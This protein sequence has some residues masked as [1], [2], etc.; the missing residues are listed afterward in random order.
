MAKE[1]RDQL[2][3]IIAQLDGHFRSDDVSPAD[4]DGWQKLKR[5][6]TRMRSSLS[7]VATSIAKM[8]ELGMPMTDDEARKIEAMRGSGS[9]WRTNHPVIPGNPVIGGPMLGGGRDMA[10]AGRTLSDAQC[11]RMATLLSRFRG[12]RAMNLEM[13]DGF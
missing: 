9:G 6:I 4:A 12:S 3:H 7:L 13:L 2:L 10:S 1:K 11:D 8:R 5:H